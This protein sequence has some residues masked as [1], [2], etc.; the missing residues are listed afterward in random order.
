MTMKFTCDRCTTPSL[1]KKLGGCATIHGP[2]G[3]ITGVRNPVPDEDECLMDGTEYT[4]DVNPKDARGAPKVS[5]SI[6]PEIA[7]VEL[8]QAFRDG[9]RKYGPFNW[10]GSSVRTS[11]YLD[12]ISRHFKL[13]KMGQDKADDSGLG[14]L[15]HIMSN[16]VILLD[17]ELNGTLVD[18]RHKVS[19]EVIQRFEEI[20]EMYRL[21]NA[22]A[23]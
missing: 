8:S 7:E 11:V 21:K 1:C 10:R 5:V 9:N 19:P 4:K 16:C 15:T 14:H 18:D 13:Y 20:L 12:A 22:H 23:T 17:A 2:E 6:V 3:S